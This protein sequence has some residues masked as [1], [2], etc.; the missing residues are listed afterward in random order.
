MTNAVRG[1][2]SVELAGQTYQLEFTI[3]ALCQLEARLAQ[4]A[5]DLLARIGQDRSLA[6]VRTLLWGA[7][8]EHHGALTEKQA[9][10]LLRA[11]GGGAL[12]AKTLEAF[13]AAW[14]DGA[15][16]GD[17]EGDQGGDAAAN[18]PA[19]QSTV[20]AGTGAPSASSGSS[21]T[22]GRRTPTG[23]RRRAASS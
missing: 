8:R 9:G 17:P 20:P 12:V 10:E 13:V 5:V 1:R 7:L 18:P 21:A 19:R 3:D 4:P 6:F 2:V 22:P 23:G 15:L 11:E 16:E 14:P